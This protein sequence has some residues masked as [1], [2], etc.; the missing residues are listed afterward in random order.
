VP[1][2]HRSLPLSLSLSLSLS[3]LTQIKLQTNSNHLTI[4]DSFCAILMLG[5]MLSLFK[6]WEVCCAGLMVLTR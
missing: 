2:P 3:L 1:P 6:R 4:S 5:L